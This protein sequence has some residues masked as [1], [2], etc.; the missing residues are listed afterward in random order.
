M[1]SYQSTIKSESAV[2][3]VV[4]LLLLLGAVLIAPGAS[5]AL[6]PVTP[7]PR[8]IEYDPDK[9]RLGQQLFS[10]T[11][12]SRDRTISCASCH[13]LENGGDDPRPVSL[14]V[15]GRKGRVNSPT[16][17]NAVFNFRQFWNG[18]A[19]D[20]SEQAKGPLQDQNEMGM[21]PRELEERL[22]ATPDYREKFR[23]LYGDN[24][25]TFARIIDALVH[26]QRALITPDSPFDLHLRQEAQLDAGQLRG[27]LT[28]KKIG[29]ITCHNGVNLGGNSYQKIGVINPLPD[30]EAVPDRMELSDDPA[31]RHLFKVPSLRNIALTAPYFHDASS[32]TLHEAMEYMAYHNLGVELTSGQIDNLNAFLLSL[33]GKPPAILNNPESKP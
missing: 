24:A 26:F 11:L 5:R 21:T 10:D 19:A 6:E 13:D 22:E 12:L 30:Q 32:S 3:P 33:T 25:I 8:S 23:R 9:A 15:E 1:N 7:I 2:K 29:C 4:V 27:Y 14:G 17:F 20:L 28:F 31:D 16:V 18:R